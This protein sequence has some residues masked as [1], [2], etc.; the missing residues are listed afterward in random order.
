MMVF[1]NV[2]N[3]VQFSLVVLVTFLVQL[4]VEA[5]DMVP[6]GRCAPSAPCEF[7]YDEF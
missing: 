5:N 3:N 2:W 4:V 7:E 6:D 1:A